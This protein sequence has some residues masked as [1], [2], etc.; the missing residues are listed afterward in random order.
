MTGAASGIGAATAR[1]LAQS[2]FDVTGVDVDAEGLDRLH[3]AGVTV[4]SI[5]LD[6]TDRTA[7]EEALAD[8]EVDALVNAA[9]L[10]PDTESARL[11]W[12]V[13]LLAPLWVSNA[14]DVRPR[15]SIVNVAS[16]T[17]ELADGRHDALLE[18]PL[19]ED[20]LEDIVVAVP[21]PVDAY[22]FSKRALLQETE[23]S[24]ARMAPG[25]RVNAVSPGVIETPMGTRSMT[26][27]WTRK[28]VRHI[29]AGRLGQP[30]E[31]AEVIGFLL[32]DRAA[33]VSGA[34]L[35]V[36]GGYVASRT[37]VGLRR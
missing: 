4:R 25:V 16:I 19:R 20:F 30:E 21:A 27:D 24:A 28:A 13:N 7:V 1:Y 9:G 6:L 12:T 5:A 18:R 3:G 26:F 31:V 35:V 17:G 32:S 11:I 10:G 23:R 22:K 14:V 34:R 36:D 33:Y 15:G 8:V 2:G 37:V 29:P